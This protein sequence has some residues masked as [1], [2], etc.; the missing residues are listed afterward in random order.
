MKELDE[1]HQHTEQQGRELKSLHRLNQEYKNIIAT[2]KEK[3]TVFLREKDK[4]TKMI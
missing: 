2:F 1:L 4:L 3:I